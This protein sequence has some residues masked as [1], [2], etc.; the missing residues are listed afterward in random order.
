LLGDYEGR[1]D[2]LQIFS[3]CLPFSIFQSSTGSLQDLQLADAIS[4][5]VD[6]IF[7]WRERGVTRRLLGDLKGSL[8]GKE[9]E[10]KRKKERRKERERT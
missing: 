6:R 1:S 9:S 8:E 4:T 3:C 7:T 2:F 10:T 5:N